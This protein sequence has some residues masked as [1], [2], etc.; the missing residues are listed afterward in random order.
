MGRIRCNRVRGGRKA[1]NRR[2]NKYLPHAG[3]N[4]SQC[5]RNIFQKE[6][7][8]KSIC[9]FY[10]INYCFQNIFKISIKRNVIPLSTPYK[11]Y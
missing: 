7:G 6:L 5:D 1:I 9:V 2:G 8:N 10:R 4:N 11:I 3:D